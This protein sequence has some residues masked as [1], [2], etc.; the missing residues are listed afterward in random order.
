M[1]LDKGADNQYRP[2]EGYALAGAGELLSGRGVAARMALPDLLA[3]ARIG[4]GGGIG[5]AGHRRDRTE[6][7]L[8]PPELLLIHSTDRSASGTGRSGGAVGAGIVRDHQGGLAVAI[9]YRCY[10]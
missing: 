6:A 4:V 8:Q 1:A 3:L 5:G 7:L 9:G 2:F 10:R